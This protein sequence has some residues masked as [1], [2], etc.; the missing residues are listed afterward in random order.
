ME[1][2]QKGERDKDKVTV[3]NNIDKDKDGINKTVIF[4]IKECSKKLNSRARKQ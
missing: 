4:R 3:I 2:C 1:I